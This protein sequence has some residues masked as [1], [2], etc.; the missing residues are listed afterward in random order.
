MTDEGL[1]AARS[2]YTKTLD[3]TMA[4]SDFTDSAS[5]RHASLATS[6][7]LPA[8]LTQRLALD[9]FYGWLLDT[10]E[11]GDLPALPGAAARRRTRRRGLRRPDG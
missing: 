8:A 7:A 5:S 1:A 9:A 4:A 2:E 10:S 11:R 3:T 6:L